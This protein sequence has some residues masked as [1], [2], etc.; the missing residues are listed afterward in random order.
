MSYALTHINT[1]TDGCKMQ[2]SDIFLSVSVA[3]VMQLN[4]RILTTLST[5]PKVRSICLYLNS[6]E[7]DQSQLA[8]Q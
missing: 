7:M 3:Q 6:L 2:F 4:Q 5:T 8:E 1:A